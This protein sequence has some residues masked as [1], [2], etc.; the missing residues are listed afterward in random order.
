MSQ[1]ILR[2]PCFPQQLLGFSAGFNSRIKQGFI[3]SFQLNCFSGCL[4]RFIRASARSV[5]IAMIFDGERSPFSALSSPGEMMY[6]NNCQPKAEELV[7]LP[8]CCVR[9]G[10]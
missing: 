4:V 7:C 5:T 6:L 8:Q 3:C 1:L 2:R 9:R 10:M